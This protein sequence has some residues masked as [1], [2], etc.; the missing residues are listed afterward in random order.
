[1]A[2]NKKKVQT[3]EPKKY[4]FLQKL[5]YLYIIPFL[6]SIT[7]ALLLLTYWGIN[8][9][10]EIKQ[11]T[12][13]RSIQMEEEKQEEEEMIRTNTSEQEDTNTNNSILQLEN[14]V[15]E[16]QNEIIKL[17]AELKIANETIDELKEQREELN[18]SIKEVATM[19]ERM[20][21]KKAAQ[22]LK[23][24]DEDMTLQILKKLSVNKRSAIL[25]QLDPEIAA[26]YTERLASN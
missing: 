20:S 14:E 1:M 22:I 2:K 16:K 23:E 26:K 10:E 18:L 6:F 8:V 12:E 9:F 3:E 5:F 4:S 13:Q 11:F 19:Y 24:L 7:I 21:T 17:T 25:G 15:I